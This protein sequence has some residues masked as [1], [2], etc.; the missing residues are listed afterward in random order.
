MTTFIDIIELA[1]A[2]SQP[3]VV[4][5]EAIRTLRC[6]GQLRAFDW[7]LSDPPGSA[8]AGDR[9]I[10]GPGATG[11]WAG[12]DDE[13]AYYSGSAWVFLQPEPGWRCW[14]DTVNGFVLYNPGS[15]TQPWVL[16]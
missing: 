6:L 13:Y 4:V 15:A 11:D 1:A 12:H 9:Y 16:D 10:V 2:Q 3:E 5:N 8:G 7:E 14:V